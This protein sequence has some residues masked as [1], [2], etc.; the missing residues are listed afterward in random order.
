[1]NLTNR[2]SRIKTFLTALAFLAFQCCAPLTVKPPSPAFDEEKIAAILS[3]FEAQEG[4]AKTLFFSGTLTLKIR[5]GETDVQILMVAEAGFLQTTKSGVSTGTCPYGRMKIEITHAWGK[6]L[7]HLLI[8]GRRLDILD[9]TEKR[10]YTG[11]FQSKRLSELIP[12]PLDPAVLWSLVRAF[13][14]LLE[15]RKTASFAGNHISLMDAAGGEIQALELFSEEPLPHRVCFCKQNATL[16]FSDFEN[17]DGIL[18]A[19]QVDFHGPNR[20]ELEIEISKMTFNA[21]LP[22]AVFSMDV[23]PDFTFVHLGNHDPEH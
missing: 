5:D 18:Y 20:T 14:V 11:G 3:T 13:P 21:P 10:F 17:D 19:R 23:P 9:F 12:V 7:L 8:Q 6:P 16:V 22:E 4:A 1:L 15:H 2:H